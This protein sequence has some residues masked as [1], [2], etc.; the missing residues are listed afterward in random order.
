MAWESTGLLKGSLWTLHVTAWYSFTLFNFL[1]NKGQNFSIM[2][3]LVGSNAL[4]QHQMHTSRFYT[5]ITAT[6]F[7][8]SARVDWRYGHLRT[9]LTVE[10]ECLIVLSKSTSK[11]KRHVFLDTLVNTCI[12]AVTEFFSLWNMKMNSWR[13]SRDLWLW[14]MQ[15]SEPSLLN[16]M[17]F[18]V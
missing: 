4:K 10:S 7:W 3:L 6:T 2:K 18:G 9:A 1:D 12:Y 8:S 13:L 17:V 5:S 14:L 16:F 11:W 15:A